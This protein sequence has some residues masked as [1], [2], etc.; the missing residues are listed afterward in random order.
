MPKFVEKMPEDYTSEGM[1]MDKH[2]TVNHKSSH[3]GE[4]EMMEMS[5]DE[6]VGKVHKMGHH[7]ME[8]GP[9]GG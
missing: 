5:H 3:T 2:K 9:M 7:V 8:D 1:K 4:G 6:M